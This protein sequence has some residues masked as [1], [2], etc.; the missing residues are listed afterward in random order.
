MHPFM[1]SMSP[2]ITHNTVDIPDEMR[3]R[4]LKQT[5]NV[6][7]KIDEVRKQLELPVDQLPIV[8]EIYGKVV[9]AM[10]AEEERKKMAERTRRLPLTMRSETTDYQP[11]KITPGKSVDVI[12]RPQTI[13][14]PEDIAIHGDRARWIVH[15]I[16]IGNRSQFVNKRGP[17]PGTEF[18]PGGIL[19]HLKLETAQTAMDIKLVVEY[20]GPE[21]DGEVFEATMVGLATDY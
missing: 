7:R 19:E 2:S 6:L 18:G 5:A 12:I 15:D 11:M 14:R 21:S 3:E 16:L 10:F 9:M 20:V 1:S 13:Y 8:L 17:A 4:A